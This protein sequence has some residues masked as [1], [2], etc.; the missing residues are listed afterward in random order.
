MS[1]KAIDLKE[2]LES[3][4]C[5][6]EA[7]EPEVGDVEEFED[8]ISCLAQIEVTSIFLDFTLIKFIF[9]FP[10]CSFTSSPIKNLLNMLIAIQKHQNLPK[11]N[12]CKTKFP[13]KTPEIC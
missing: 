5:C 1:V 8:L 9:N 12:N 11:S 6:L 10:A 2:Y 7:V 4:R 13:F 3:C